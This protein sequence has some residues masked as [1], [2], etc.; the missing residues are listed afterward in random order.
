MIRLVKEI[1]ERSQGLPRMRGDDPFTSNG[2]T[3]LIWF[4]PHARG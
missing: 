3:T 4:A 2:I 1:N